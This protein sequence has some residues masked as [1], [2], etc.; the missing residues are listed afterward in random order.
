M[1][2]GIKFL[3][4]LAIF[5]LA[6]LLAGRTAAA[7]ALRKNAR[8]WLNL[9]ILLAV[10]VVCLSGVLRT[11]ARTPKEAAPAPA[12]DQAAVENQAFAAQAPLD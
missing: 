12:A 3:L 5:A 2:F 11:A 10:L 4:A 8:M 1:V 9:N 6:S 7:E